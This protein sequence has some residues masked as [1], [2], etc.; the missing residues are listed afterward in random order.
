MT[1]IEEIARAIGPMM[2][3][4]ETVFYQGGLPDESREDIVRAVVKAMREPS[5]AMLEGYANCLRHYSPDK[6]SGLLRWQAMI[7]ALLAEK[8]E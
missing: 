4:Y 2:D 8:T 1:K 7:D 3:G 5:F 6:P